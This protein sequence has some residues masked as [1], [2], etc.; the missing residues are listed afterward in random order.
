MKM[1]AAFFGA[2]N[3]LCLR[4]GKVQANRRGGLSSTR[5][6]F[7]SSGGVDG[8]VMH[9]DLEPKIWQLYP[10]VLGA[11]SQKAM[12]RLLLIGQMLYPVHPAAPA[13]LYLGDGDQGPFTNVLKRLTFLC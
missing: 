9:E 6:T 5:A 4:V 13:L 8:V 11:P 12:R 10:C 1:Q 7:L 3:S 2:A